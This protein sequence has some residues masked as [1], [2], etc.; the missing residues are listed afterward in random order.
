MAPETLTEYE[1]RR[2][3]N[4]KKNGEMMASLMLRRKAADLS[5]FASAKRARTS[6]NPPKPK[7]SNPPVIRR[8]PRDRALLLRPPSSLPPTPL[9][10]PTS[11]WKRPSNSNPNPAPT[12]ASSTRSLTWRAPRLRPPMEQPLLILE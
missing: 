11:P 5:S 7:P 3:E 8:S 1:R 10:S 9:A 4:I 12:A 2:L 6:Q